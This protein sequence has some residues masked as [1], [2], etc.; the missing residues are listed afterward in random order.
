MTIKEQIQKKIETYKSLANH[1]TSYITAKNSV[2]TKLRDQI[3]NLEMEGG[4]NYTR[5][6]EAM[7]KHL[8][9]IKTNK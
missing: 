7:A 2:L 5:A 8:K 9:N 1:P 4:K 6:T 3:V